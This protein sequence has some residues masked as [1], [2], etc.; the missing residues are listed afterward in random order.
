MGPDLA[1]LRWRLTRNR[2]TRAVYGALTARGVRAAKLDR[3]ELP[4][5]RDPP[6]TSP[7]GVTFETLPVD[8]V[9]PGECR[10][11]DELEDEDRAVFA[12]VDGAVVG[13]VFVSDRP[14]EVSVVGR[15]LD[16][17]H[18]RRLF[19][20]PDHRRHGIGTAL[21]GQAVTAARKAFE[22]ETASALVAVDTYPAKRVLAVNGFEPRERLTYYRVGS[23]ERRAT[24]SL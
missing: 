20:D 7:E 2:V 17:A 21:V 12:R 8:A 6:S 24:R 1:A 14:L 11:A 4:G 23:W 15:R 22:A 5:D 16:G 10:H 13:Q 9:D 19:V 3:Y 18:L